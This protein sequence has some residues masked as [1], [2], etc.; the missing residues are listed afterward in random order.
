[1]DPALQKNHQRTRRSGRGILSRRQLVV[2]E[3]EGTQSERKTARARSQKAAS[4]RKKNFQEVVPKPYMKPPC[5]PRPRGFLLVSGGVITRDGK[6]LG[7]TS[8]GSIGS[9]SDD[10][11]LIVW[12]DSELDR[13][14]ALKKI[15]EQYA[16]FA[17][18]LI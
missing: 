4:L 11:A 3:R 9:S 8:I 7:P 16:I 6:V 17:E 18:R 15:G 2:D 13:E 10:E 12:L 14:T 1:M 5:I